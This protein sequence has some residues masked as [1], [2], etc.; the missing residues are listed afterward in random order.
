MDDPPWTLKF[1]VEFH[2]EFHLEFQV[3]SHDSRSYR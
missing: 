3:T 2:L 1:Q